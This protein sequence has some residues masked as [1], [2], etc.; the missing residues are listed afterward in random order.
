MKRM[1]KKEIENKLKE[2]LI[3][4][5]E[6]DNNDIYVNCVKFKGFTNKD[7][8]YAKEIIVSLEIIDGVSLT[9]LKNKVEEYLY[10]IGMDYSGLYVEI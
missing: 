9:I 4:K 10:S 7:K 2:L 3:Q 1:S 5:D 6:F 8:L